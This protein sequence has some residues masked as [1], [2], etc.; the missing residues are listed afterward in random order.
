MFD[1]KSLSDHWTYVLNQVSLGN[2]NG[3]GDSLLG[4][5]HRNLMIQLVRRETSQVCEYPVLN[6]QIFSTQAIVITGVSR[7]QSG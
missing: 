5:S 1:N 2:A 3:L 7:G 6:R 4:H